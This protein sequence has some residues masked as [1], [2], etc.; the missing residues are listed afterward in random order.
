MSKVRDTSRFLACLV[1]AAD[2]TGSLKVGVRHVA[3]RID[4]NEAEAAFYVRD[5]GS[6][7]FT[8]LIVVVRCQ[9]YVQGEYS[10]K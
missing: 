8:G 7:V 3:R 6:A 10:S 9:R 5:N 2:W 1:H 4:F